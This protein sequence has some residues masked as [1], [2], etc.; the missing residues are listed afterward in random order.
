MWT[1]RFDLVGLIWG[2]DLSVYVYGVALEKKMLA[3]L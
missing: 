3:L 1:V 2:V